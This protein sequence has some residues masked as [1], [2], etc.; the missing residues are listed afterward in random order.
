MA[1]RPQ[2]ST[3]RPQIRQFLN[4]DDIRD[5]M[6]VAI[7]KAKAGDVIMSKFLL[8]QSFGKA[9]QTM[10]ITS[11]GEKII[12]LLNYV[13][14]NFSDNKNTED[15]EKDKGNTGGNISE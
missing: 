2:G 7:K 3:N 6:A 5:I 13:R 11:G 1:G 10:D 8:E 9:P 4:D 12:P 14:N 15:E